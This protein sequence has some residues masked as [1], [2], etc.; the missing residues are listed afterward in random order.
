MNFF[1]F[2]RKTKSFHLV[3]IFFALI[4]NIFFFNNCSKNYNSLDLNKEL[5]SPETLPND[6]AP[7]LI[8][9]TGDRLSYVCKP[10]EIAKTPAIKLSKR[11]FKDALFGLVK[12][13]N[14]DIKNT[15]DAELDA[16]INSIPSDD[17]NKG[18]F[19]VK[20]D[21]FAQSTRSVSTYFEAAFKAGSLVA[22][23]YN[24]AE[25]N[26]IVPGSG[27]CLKKATVITQVCHQ[28]LVK[29]LASNAFRKN[30]D[31]AAT[32]SLSNTLW[33][34]ILTRE[35]LIQLTFT[36]IV[37]MPEFMYRVYDQGTVSPRGDRVITMNAFDL[38]T[39]VSYFLVGKAPDPT[40]RN[41]AA[42]GQIL[43][44]TILSQQVDRLLVT[45]DAKENIKKIIS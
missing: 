35:E 1:S 30:L 37:Q 23:S 18:H 45:A 20:E 39:K 14:F 22:N 10:N 29:Q 11:E 13:F 31:I 17:F 3:L 6:F 21:N 4:I 24:L 41:L 7:P 33:D 15:G 9:R 40:L 26:D 38:A 28:N 34:P 36:A 43:D 5:S 25:Y 12:A 27:S 2:N 16:V 8:N 32:N 44:N 19:T 42:N